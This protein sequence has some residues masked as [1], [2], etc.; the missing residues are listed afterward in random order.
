MLRTTF[1]GYAAC[2]LEQTTIVETKIRRV[3]KAGRPRE[4]SGVLLVGS[5]ISRMVVGRANC[6]ERHSLS[7]ERRRQCAS[8]RANR[9]GEFAPFAVRSFWGVRGLSIGSTAARD[10]VIIFG[11]WSR[12]RLAPLLQGRGSCSSRASDVQLAPGSYQRAQPFSNTTFSNASLRFNRMMLAAMRAYR[13]S[14][15]PWVQPEAWGVQ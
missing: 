12:T 3:W 11:W 1:I 13:R 9:A 10:S 14:K 15:R 8:H 5:D 7:R 4:A 2:L 6:H